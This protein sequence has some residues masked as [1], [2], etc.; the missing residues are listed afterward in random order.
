MAL[1]TVAS[2]IESQGLIFANSG[3]GSG[4]RSTIA[5]EPGRKGQA[6]RLAWEN[7]NKKVLPYVPSMLAWGDYL[8]VLHDQPGIASC[9]VAKTGKIVWTERLGGDFSASPI[10]IEGKIYAVNE[11]GEVYVFPAEPNF[12]LSAKNRIGEPVIAT[13]AV[14]DGRLLIRGKEHLFCIG[15]SAAK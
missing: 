11:E 5:V 7:Q 13:P 4:A 14:A 8:F 12:H 6:A 15:K 10:L 1:R 2:P 3:D 9:L